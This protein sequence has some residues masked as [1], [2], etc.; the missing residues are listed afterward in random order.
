MWNEEYW[1]G[2]LSS[3][4]KN[5]DSTQ[6]QREIEEEW[7]GKLKAEIQPQAKKDANCGICLSDQ[8]E[9]ETLLNNCEHSYCAYCISEWAEVSSACPLCRANFSILI[10]LLDKSQKRVNKRKLVVPDYIGIGDHDLIDHSEDCTSDNNSDGDND[11]SDDIDDDEDEDGEENEDVEGDDDGEDDEADINSDASSESSFDPQL[12]V[13]RLKYGAQESVVPQTNAPQ[14]RPL[15]RR[16]HYLDECEDIEDSEANSKSSSECYSPQRE[17]RRSHR[18]K[19]FS[20]RKESEDSDYDSSFI[21]DD[22][23][24]EA[25]STDSVIFGDEVSSTDDDEENLDST[26]IEDEEDDDLK[27]IAEIYTLPVPPRQQPKRRCTR[28]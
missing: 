16:T 22:D 26:R 4:T 11:D 13:L 21:V 3:A 9:D 14:R 1:F 15:I 6:P 19:Q 25:D 7:F 20:L 10:R 23:V 27:V 2:P 18:S 28:K 24:I 8:K 12:H 17:P 5:N